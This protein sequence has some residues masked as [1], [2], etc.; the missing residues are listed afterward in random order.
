MINLLK[1]MNY[2]EFKGEEFNKYH[3]ALEEML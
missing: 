1:Q 2:N 3:K